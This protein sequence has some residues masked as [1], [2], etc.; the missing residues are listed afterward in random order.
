[1]EAAMVSPE[2][3]DHRPTTNEAAD[4]RA[5]IGN[6]KHQYRAAMNASAGTPAIYWNLF[7]PTD[8]QWAR[9]ERLV[10][11]AKSELAESDH[12]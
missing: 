1:M 4:D 3:T 6:L 11:V 12:A 5:Y 8:E 9:H 2:T 10:S 7:N